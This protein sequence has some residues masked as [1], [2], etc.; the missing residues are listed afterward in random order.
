MPAAL[1]TALEDGTVRTSTDAEGATAYF[2]APGVADKVT[3]RRAITQR[4]LS[5]LLAVCA[6]GIAVGTAL[7]GIAE[8]FS[9]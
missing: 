7:A 2:I 4:K 8:F 9:V 5:E 1:A 6:F 3:I